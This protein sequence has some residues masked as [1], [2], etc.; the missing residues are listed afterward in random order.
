VIDFLDAASPYGKTLPAF[1]S[2][3]LA[4]MAAMRV[5]IAWFYEHTQIVALAQFIY[6]SSAGSPVVLIPPTVTPTPEATWCAPDAFDLWHLV[7]LL[8]RS[9]PSN[10]RPG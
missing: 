8:T 5:L 6:L 2:A 9:F 4:A 3:F 7:L 10:R 1:W